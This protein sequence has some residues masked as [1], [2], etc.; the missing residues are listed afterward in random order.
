MM[1][2][3]ITLGWWIIPAVLSLAA[4][5]WCGKQDYSGDYNFT[6]LITLPVTG[7]AICFVWMIYFGLG[8]ALT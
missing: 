4:I 1:D 6:A 8:W 2:M 5:H 3:T 7:L